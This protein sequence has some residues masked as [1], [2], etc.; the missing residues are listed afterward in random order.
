MKKFILTLGLCGIIAPGLYAQNAFFNALYLVQN[1][2]N[3]QQLNLAKSFVDFSKQEL[4]EIKL[5]INFLKK[6]FNL[7]PRVPNIQVL[8]SAIK[9]MVLA[10]KNERNQTVDG[11]LPIMN[12]LIPSTFKKLS[13]FSKMK[14]AGIYK[15][16]TQYIVAEFKKGVTL[17]FFEAFEKT[18][19]NTGEFRLFFPSTYDALKSR[20]PSRFPALGTHW[21]EVF[22]KDLQNVVQNLVRFVENPSPDITAHAQFLTKEFTQNLQTTPSFE[23]LK[24]GNDIASKLLDRFH[25]IDLMN[26][27]D[28]KYFQNPNGKYSDIGAMLHKLNVLQSNL[29]DTTENIWVNFEQIN[30]LNTQ[31]IGIFAGLLYQAS[32]QVF[33]DMKAQVSLNNEVHPA[34][35]KKYLL[36]TILPVYEGLIKIQGFEKSKGKNLYD[37]SY[38]T[39]MQHF[40]DLLKVADTKLMSSPVLYQPEGKGTTGNKFNQGNVLQYTVE[41]YKSIYQKKYSQLISNLSKILQQLLDQSGQNT[42]FIKLLT[43]LDRFGNFITGVAN[44][45]NAAQLHDLLG[46]FLNTTSG[47]LRKRTSQQTLSIT[48]HPGYYGS[49]EFLATTHTWGLNTGI[50]IPLGLEYTLGFTSKT[51]LNITRKGYFKKNNQQRFYKGNSLGIF[52]QIIDVGALINYRFFDDQ[53]QTLP[54]TITFH[55]LLAPGVSINYG[56]K[57]TPLTLGVGYQYM[58]QLRK[59]N[60]PVSSIPQ[61]SSGQRFFFR[62]SWD[63]PLL[64]IWAK[65]GGD[66]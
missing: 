51:A 11:G 37:Q 28:L 13:S 7:Y 30:R 56:F 61:F 2:K 49:G 32:P 17:S 41:V 55:Q 23:S 24:L 1:Q 52:M 47:Y 15:G 65:K 59:V 4:E 44:A 29:R 39:Y 48:A 57:N 40:V 5:S 3:I 34:K 66:K 64:H 25:P 6:P 9:K 58:P 33:A 21:K 22:H 43:K 62:I 42:S 54:D 31:H 16:I 60:H 38:G 20:D 53:T 35:C 26:Y 63:L 27:L 36:E 19:D 46:N 10:S 50:T 8:Q 12:A 45:N 18:F 14:N